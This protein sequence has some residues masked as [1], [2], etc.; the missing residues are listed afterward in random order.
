M[1]QLVLQDAR[2]PQELHVQELQ[3]LNVWQ[4]NA[5]EKKLQCVLLM[6]AKYHLSQIQLS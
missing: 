2:I 1:T 4:V 5:M 6:N 3:Y